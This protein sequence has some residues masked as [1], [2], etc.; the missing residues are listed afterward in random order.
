M[1]LWR[2]SGPTKSDLRPSVTSVRGQALYLLLH[3]DSDWS[4]ARASTENGNSYERPRLNHGWLSPAACGRGLKPGDWICCL[5][6]W[7]F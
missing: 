6:A 1:K 5:F 7:L 4:P 2:L 3:R